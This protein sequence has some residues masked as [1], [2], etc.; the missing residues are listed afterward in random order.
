[1]QQKTIL[2]ISNE[3][4]INQSVN[5]IIA[6]NK[7]VIITAINEQLGLT[8]ISQ[9][10]PDLIFC[11]LNTPEIN[12]YRILTE[13]RNNSHTATIPFI[14]ITSNFDAGQWRQGMNLGAD[15]FLLQPFTTA[16]LYEVINSRFAKQEMLITQY[17]QELDYLRSSILDFLPHE[18]RTA[19]TGILASLDLLLNQLDQLNYAVIL[20][21]LGCIDAS[22]QRLSRLVHNFLLYSELSLIGQNHEQI[23]LFRAQATC[24]S[25]ETVEPIV[26]KLGQKFNRQKDISWQG[27]NVPLA[28]SQSHLAKLVEELIDNA[29]K[30]SS[31]GTPIE[32]TGRRN[33]DYFHLSVRDEGRGMAAEQIALIGACIQFDRSTYEQQGCGLGL[34]I[35][36]RLVQV[37]GGKLIINSVLNQET[38]VNVYIP[39]VKPSM[40]VGI[41]PKP[42]K[43]KDSR[44]IKIAR[45]HSY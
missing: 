40:F 12:G 21:L 1:M 5:K 20:E 45:T 25:S 7:Y 11:Q 22:S 10:S 19:L 2:V 30:F 13:V 6:S 34:A 24:L 9:K 14:F 41:Q 39:L 31:A 17:K 3:E 42:K 32:I 15:D 43:F 16:E 8:A 28:I 27:H 33:G 18:M 38:R 26:T 44:L 37:Y 36:K 29:V 35:V 23:R 4:E